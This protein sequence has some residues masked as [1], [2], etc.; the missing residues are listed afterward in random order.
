MLLG[1]YSHV[2]PWTLKRR[3]CRGEV[4][5]GT[6]GGWAS[7]PKVPA[8]RRWLTDI[9]RMV[10]VSR[11][12]DGG[13]KSERSQDKEADKAGRYF[14]TIF[15]SVVFYLPN[16]ASCRLSLRQDRGGRNCGAV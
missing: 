6:G 10:T 12:N 11:S 13:M 15:S 14:R 4:R 8:Y 2:L 5:R 1:V 16:H 7:E 9:D 3:F